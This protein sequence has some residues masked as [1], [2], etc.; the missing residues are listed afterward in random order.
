MGKPTA[1]QLEA[2]REQIL[3]MDDERALALLPGSIQDDIE[4]EWIKSFDHDDICCM[5]AAIR[6]QRAGDMAHLSARL[7]SKRDVF[8]KDQRLQ[9]QYAIA[10]GAALV[11]QNYSD[12][13]D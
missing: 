9:E 5:D 3:D 13:D 4:A 8:L 1:S 11:N 6:S 7:I 12:S 2:I 10:L